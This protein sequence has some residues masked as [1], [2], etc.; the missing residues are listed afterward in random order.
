MSPRT[1]VLIPTYDNA[2]TLEGVVRRVRDHVADVIVVDDGSH[3]DARSVAQK[4]LE[5][6]LADVRFHD[7][8]R[9]KGAAMLTGLQAADER[10]FSHAIQIDADGQH[11]TDDIPRFLEASRAEPDA[12]VMGQPIF[13][14]TAPRLRIWARKVSVFWCRVETWSRR[15][16]DPLCGYRVYPVAATLRTAFRAR[17]MDVDAEAAVRLAWAG[18]PIAHV[19]TRVRYLTAQEGGVSHFRPLLDTLHISIMHARL[20]FTALFLWLSRWTRGGRSR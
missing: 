5:S 10:G 12:L 1:C 17:A 16:G 3:D 4:L 19:A 2:L 8:N 18:T 11:D 7:K 6:G 15:L 20:T 13:D 14:A 9:G